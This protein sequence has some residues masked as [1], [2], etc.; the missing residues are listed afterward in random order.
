MGRWYCTAFEPADVLFCMFAGSVVRLCICAVA[1]SGLFTRV[2]WDDL[3]VSQ[4]LVQSLVFFCSMNLVDRL[5]RLFCFLSIL[6]YSVKDGGLTLLYMATA[7][8]FW[9]GI[10]KLIVSLQALC[11]HKH[12]FK[13][14]ER[15]ILF[16]RILPILAIPAP[17]LPSWKSNRRRS[18][19]ALIQLSMF[20]RSI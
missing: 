3:L 4:Q 2:T 5:L 19:Q 20:P 13:T 16:L 18:K 12:A 8:G 14:V 11:P 1:L 17:H 10:R 6:G 7:L 15:N 9:C